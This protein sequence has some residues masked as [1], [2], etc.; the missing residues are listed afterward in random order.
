MRAAG[1]L[2]ISTSAGLSINQRGDE[3]D[4]EDC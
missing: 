4:K 1:M 3:A 2:R